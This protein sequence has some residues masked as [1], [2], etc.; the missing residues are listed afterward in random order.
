MKKHEFIEEHDGVEVCWDFSKETAEDALTS[1]T[2]M[3]HDLNELIKTELTSFL[4][5]LL[6][7]GYCDSDVYAEP[8]T[9]LDQYLIF[10]KS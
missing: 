2:P 1:M 3:E 7:E 5:F 9:A 6:K 4:D 8:P 10:N